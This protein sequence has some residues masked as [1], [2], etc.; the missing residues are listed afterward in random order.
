MTVI[1]NSYHKDSFHFNLAEHKFLK[2][3]LH[4]I[5]PGASQKHEAKKLAC[6]IHACFHLGIPFSVK[7]SIGEL[8][9][10]DLRQYNINKQQIWENSAKIF[11]CDLL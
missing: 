10:H 4:I 9:F 1:S 6:Q 5:Q 3:N 8:K 2:T 7:S 11:A